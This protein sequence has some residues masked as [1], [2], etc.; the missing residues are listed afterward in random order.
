MARNSLGTISHT[1]LA[2]AELRRRALPLLGLVLVNTSAESSPDQPT[3]AALIALQTG[4]APMGTLPYVG[5]SREPAVLAAALESALDL[6][7]IFAA[8]ST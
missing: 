6:E 2:I 3:N 4:L 1:A 7:P 8:L 5:T